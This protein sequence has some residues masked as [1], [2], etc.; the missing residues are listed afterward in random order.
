MPGV[1]EI[2]CF[3]RL[4]KMALQSYLHKNG[5]INFYVRF[6]SHNL[7]NL[8]SLL[9]NVDFDTAAALANSTGFKERVSLWGWTNALHAVNWSWIHTYLLF[10]FSYDG[11]VT[12]LENLLVHIELSILDR[13]LLGLMLA[14][15]GRYRRYTLIQFYFRK[16][17]QQLRPPK[18]QFFQTAKNWF[19]KAFLAFMTLVWV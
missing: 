2:L 5:D 9:S 16:S 10:I 4:G 19:E 6:S 12:D 3:P 14:E 1:Q 17:I 8:K 18:S 13:K 11:R 15:S 7:F